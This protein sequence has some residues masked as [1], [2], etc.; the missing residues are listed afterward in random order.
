MADK[1]NRNTEST[2]EYVRNLEADIAQMVQQ[3]RDLSRAMER[4]DRQLPDPRI[5]V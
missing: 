4:L 3:R 1:E 5:I 2:E